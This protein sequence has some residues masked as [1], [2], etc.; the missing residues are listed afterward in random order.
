M[1]KQLY[2]EEINCDDWECENKSKTQYINR[3]IM[4]FVKYYLLLLLGADIF[5]KNTESININDQ[6]HFN[7][8]TELG[9]PN[10]EN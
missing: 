2:K 10:T 7:E 6:L 8:G 9:N 4:E 3:Q 5:R 1:I